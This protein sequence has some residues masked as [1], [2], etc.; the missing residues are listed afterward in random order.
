[1]LVGTLL[2]A[3]MAVA[4]Y[5]CPGLVPAAA[6]DASMVPTAPTADTHGDQIDAPANA[7]SSDCAGML[8]SMDPSAP[9][10]CADHCNSGHQSD[11]TPNLTVPA[12]VLSTLYL[13]PP[14]PLRL[15]PAQPTAELSAMARG[16][17]PLAILHCCFRI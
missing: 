17:P 1:M 7:Q 13:A 5:A 16:S 4:A 15:M 6:M 9:R 14:L 11:Q 12:V 10:L 8:G 3:Q 2:Y